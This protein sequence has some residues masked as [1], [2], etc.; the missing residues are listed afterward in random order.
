MGA[1]LLSGILL[2]VFG[3][4]V[5]GGAGAQTIAIGAVPRFD[6]HAC[7]G[8]VQRLR[9]RFRRFF[10]SDCPRFQLRRGLGSTN[11]TISV[12]ANTGV[13]CRS[14]CRKRIS[15]SDP[16]RKSC[17][18][19]ADYAKQASRGG[20]PHGNNLVRRQQHALWNWDAA[21]HQDVHLHW[22]GRA[23]RDGHRRAGP[24]FDH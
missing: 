12:L 16:L 11:T 17:R 15:I 21:R 4:A 19:L 7:V 24:V 10:A 13:S 3:V 5:V 18:S 1:K 20:D 2:A 14:G 9:H 6:C 22:I 8:R 23:T